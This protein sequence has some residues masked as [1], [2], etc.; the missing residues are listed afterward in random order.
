MRVLAT[1]ACILVSPSWAGSWPTATA[2]LFAGDG[3]TCEL[4][5]LPGT[6]S[7]PLWEGRV[8]AKEAKVRVINR[9]S[10]GTVPPGPEELLWTGK[11]VVKFMGGRPSEFAP[12]PKLTMAELYL[13][14][15]LLVPLWVPSAQ[16]GTRL[17]IECALGRGYL[18]LMG[19]GAPESL[20][21]RT[22]SRPLWDGSTSARIAFRHDG[23][24]S[25]WSSA[26][27]SG[28]GASP[29]V[30]LERL[31]FRRDSL[32]DD[33]FVVENEGGLKLADL[34][35]PLGQLVGSD[36]GE[37]AETAGSSA[38]FKSSKVVST[39]GTGSVYLGPVPT[40]DEV[41]RF[42]KDGELGRYADEE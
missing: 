33:L 5:I 42:L 35:K 12:G 7:R 2:A 20:V 28:R 13:L 3:A 6:G 10:T 32:S 16:S 17:Q 1:L 30:I 26:V 24:K 34:S 29:L 8:L 19:N 4:R 15:D 37:Y 22:L 9:R 40:E 25:P 41:D 27:V 21:V 31:R 36:D 23:G 18:T 14:T 11:G 38:A 39:G